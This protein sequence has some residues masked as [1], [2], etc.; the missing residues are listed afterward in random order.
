MNF[1]QVPR[2]QRDSE[3]AVLHQVE[4][5]IDLSKGPHKNNQHGKAQA[6]DGEL[7]RG[8]GLPNPLHDDLKNGWTVRTPRKQTFPS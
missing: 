3:V 8:D 5:L 2:I 4:T 6:R 7:E 1:L